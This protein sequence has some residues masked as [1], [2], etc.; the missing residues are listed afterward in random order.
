MVGTARGAKTL[1]SETHTLVSKKEYSAEPLAMRFARFVAGH[2][3]SGRATLVRAVAGVVG[4]P[5][6]FFARCGPLTILV[7]VDDIVSC[8]LYNYGEFEPAV[9]AVF[10]SLIEPA[11]I[12]LDVGANFGLFSLVAARRLQGLGGGEIIAFEPDE[13]NLARLEA[14]LGANNFTNV[15]VVRK[16]LFDRDLT[17]VLYLSDPKQKNMGTSSVLSH[18]PGQQ[19]VEIPL[20]TLDTFLRESGIASVDLIKMDIE[21][22]EFAAL[23]GA[24]AALAEG[25]IKW[26]LLELHVEIM[27]VDKSAELLRMLFAAGYQ[28]WFID[29]A[30][31]SPQA[32]VVL[33]ALS[34][35][36]GIGRLSGCPHILFSLGGL[37][38]SLADRVVP[39]RPVAPA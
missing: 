29:E 30:S 15:A 22:A 3:P 14:N 36:S 9:T 21:G 13:R 7:D 32:R 16:G 23:S 5:R 2:L 18:A 11:S 4:G 17:G 10:E 33:N 24:R 28:A 25:K 20:V 8:T 12:V 34:P 6:E 39:L 31:S 27:G 35:D 26:I 38:D 37:P 19:S 1:R